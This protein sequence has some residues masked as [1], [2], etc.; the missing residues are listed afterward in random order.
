MMRQPCDTWWRVLALRDRT[1]SVLFNAIGGPSCLMTTTTAP[2]NM[3]RRPA[4][5]TKSIRPMP[6]SRPLPR[7]PQRD[8]PADAARCPRD[9]RDLPFQRI[10]H[11]GHSRSNRVQAQVQPGDR[12][13]QLVEM[14]EARGLAARIPLAVPSPLGYRRFRPAG[15][16]CSWRKARRGSAERPNTLSRPFRI[17]V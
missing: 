6:G 11:S 13:R 7:Q 12:D 10:R 8:S 4:C 17:C 15:D 9:E 1:T 5:C 14:L 3:P 2:P 16:G